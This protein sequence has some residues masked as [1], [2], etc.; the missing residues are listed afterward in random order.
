MK[1]RTTYSSMRSSSRDGSC[2][3]FELLAF[4]IVG[5]IGGMNF[6]NMPDSKDQVRIFHCACCV[7]GLSGASITASI[8]KAQLSLL[9]EVPKSTR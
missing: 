5:D 2:R 9:K 1:C 8:A 7:F 6:Q 3:Q 4:A